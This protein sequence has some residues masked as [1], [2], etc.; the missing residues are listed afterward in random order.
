MTQAAVHKRY[1]AHQL[2]GIREE[3]R[4]ISY[5]ALQF[6]DGRVV[7]HLPEVLESLA[8]RSIDDRAQLRFLA[9]SNSRLGGRSPIRALRDGDVSRVLAAARALGEQV[10]QA[11]PAVSRMAAANL[12]SA[13]A[14]ACA[15]GFPAESQAVLRRS[16]TVANQAW[17]QEPELSRGDGWVEQLRPVVRHGVHAQRHLARGE[18]LLRRGHEEATIGP[19]ASPRSPPARAP[20][21]SDRGLDA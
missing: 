18:P 3:R 10:P 11:V 17:S 5:P 13:S 6:S 12:C 4:R 20:P 14:D 19:R 8:A 21:A 7:E 15:A 9:G 16:A 1:K 2:L